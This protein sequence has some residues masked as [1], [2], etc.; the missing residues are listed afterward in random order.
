MEWSRTIFCQDYILMHL[1]TQYL[2]S[3]IFL[4]AVRAVV[5]DARTLVNQIMQ[6]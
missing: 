4:E 6:D 3:L 2:H 1:N 5:I